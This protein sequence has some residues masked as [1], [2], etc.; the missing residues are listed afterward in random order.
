MFK[1]NREF[2][3]PL[4]YEP[5]RTKTGLTNA[6]EAELC[7]LANFIDWTKRDGRNVNFELSAKELALI[8]TAIETKIYNDMGA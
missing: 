1:K 2:L 7:D 8:E 6:T 5:L 3:E 4:I